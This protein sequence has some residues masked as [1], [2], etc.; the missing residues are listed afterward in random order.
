M[1]RVALRPLRPDDRAR[2]Y[3]W[4]NQDD[5]RRWMYNDHRIAPEEHDRWFDS[6][7]AEADAAEPRR[8]YRVIL[9]DDAPVGLAN[10]YDVER[11]F[12]RASW[13][14]YLGE[15]STRGKGV[16]A[17]VEWLML[18]T[19]FSVLKL[20]KL[21]C[22]V[23]VEN[24]AVWKTHLGFGFREEA[25][26]RAH[27]VKDGRPV[28]VLGLGV[29]AEEWAALRDASRARLTDKGLFLGEPG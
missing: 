24:E 28:D 7:L 12:G 14:Y 26:L 8:I 11:R 4:R 13:A 21:W 2:L 22:E 6:A 20:R 17:A 5:V 27:V 1:T 19:A 10:L 15:A 18:E 25:R 29:L 3:D 23:L 9:M 16:G